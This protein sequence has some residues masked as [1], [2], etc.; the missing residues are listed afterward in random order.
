MSKSKGHAFTLVA[1]SGED[2]KQHVCDNCGKLIEDRNL[3][4][5]FPNIPDLAQRVAPGAEVPSGECPKCGAL[6]YVSPFKT[7]VEATLRDVMRGD[8][9]SKDIRVTLEISEEGVFVT[10]DGYGDHCSETGHG[11]PLLLEFADGKF[12]AVAWQD[13]NQEDHTQILEFEDAR[14]EQRKED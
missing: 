14:E 8:G 11:V 10:P 9:K 4:I 12:R 13:I 7:R 5:R 1:P 6:A 2:A 3:K